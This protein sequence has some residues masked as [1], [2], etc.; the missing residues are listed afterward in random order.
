MYVD[1]PYFSVRSDNDYTR[2]Y[3]FL[4]GL[5]SYWRDLDLQEHTKTKKFA[6]PHREFQTRAAAYESFEVLFDA[7]RA[8]GHDVLV[9]YSSNCLPSRAEMVAM[10]RAR[11]RAVEAVSIDH[12]YSFGTH[13]HRVGNS[14][15]RVEEYLFFAR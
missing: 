10:L 12:V 11:W 4:E 14:N 6:S 7:L 9:S 15:N 1:P 5:V 8:G 2:R 3:H 13:A